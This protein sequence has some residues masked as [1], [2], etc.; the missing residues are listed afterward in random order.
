[1]SIALITGSCGLVGL[2]TSYFFSKK[3][4]KVVGVDND[5]RKYFFGN[6]ASTHKYL[7]KLKRDILDYEHYDIDIRDKILLEKI[8]S[9]YHKD[10]AI[11]IHVAAQPSHDWA[12][13]DPHL[14]FQINANGTLNLLDL[15]KKYCPEAVFIYASTN[16]VYGDEPNNLPLAERKTRFEI[17]KGHKYYKGINEDMGIDKSMHSLFGVSKLAADIL[18]QEYGLYFGMKT[19]CFRAGCITG[20]FHCPAQFHGFLSYLIKCFVLKIPYSI[21]GYRGKQ[22]RDN[23]HSWDLVN[24]FWQFFKSPKKGE[25]YNIGGGRDNSISVLETIKFLE[26]TTKRKMKTSY[27]PVNRKGDHMWWITDFSKF[28][29]HYPLWSLKYS[30]NEIIDEIYQDQK[31]K[32]QV[33]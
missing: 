33:V 19:V 29:S 15:T 8:F 10:I 14:D 30:L 23:I 1:M 16:K 4:F 12:A 24:A 9:K 26:D 6:E 25:V 18:V 21:I 22:I 27:I 13:K 20:S 5:M 7:E 3:G 2:E 32:Q 28:K 17:S 31:V 11:V